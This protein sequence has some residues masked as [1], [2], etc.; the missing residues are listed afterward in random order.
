MFNMILRAKY[1]CTASQICLPGLS[2]TRVL[3]T[4]E[5]DK[6]FLSLTNPPERSH[7]GFDGVVSL[8]IRVTDCSVEISHSVCGFDSVRVKNTIVISR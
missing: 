1:N 5:T 7:W 3:N 8:H 6:T 4:N 2:L